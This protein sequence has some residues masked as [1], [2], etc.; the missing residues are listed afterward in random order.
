M[1][2]VFMGL[3][4]IFSIYLF[5][6][7]DFD[8][9]ELEVDHP[10]SLSNLVRYLLFGTINSFFAGS[11]FEIDWLIWIAL[12]SVMGIIICTRSKKAEKE[13]SQ[14]LTF[15]FIVLLFFSM[16]RVPTHPASIENYINSK[17]MFK[18]VNR[19]ECVKITPVITDR[20]EIKTKVEILSVK[21]DTFD[22]YLLFARA[23]FKLADDKGKVEE[24]KAVNICGFWIEY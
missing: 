5:F 14:K 22:W 7:K 20:N 9:D 24:I 18:C 1:D 15:A 23:S 21:E 2:Y 6:V 12:Y 4:F 8:K 16:Y 11:L 13:L 19:V 17:A 10:E 3:I